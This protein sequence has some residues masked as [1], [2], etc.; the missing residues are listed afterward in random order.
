MKLSEVM[1]TNLEVISADAT[2]RDAAARMKDRDIGALPVRVGDQL[3]GM[4]T[5]RDLIVRSIAR[6]EDPDETRVATVM[7][8][9]TACCYADDEVDNAVRL[10]AD[11]QIQRLLVLDKSE[12]LVG[13]VSLADLLR[14][15]SN[16]SAVTNTLEEIKS[17][18]KTSAAGVSAHQV[19]H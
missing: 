1:Q 19:G 6:G 18:T 4:I 16:A 13:I 2:V 5:D 7:T 14:A 17:P 11:R 3:A 12:K 15:R 9:D 10:M 8:K